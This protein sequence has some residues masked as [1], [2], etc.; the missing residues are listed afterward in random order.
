MSNV[1]KWDRWYEGLQ[2]SPSSFRFADTITYELGAKFLQDCAVVEDWGVGAGGFKRYRPDAIGIDGSKTPFADKIAD[3]VSYRSHVDGIFMRHV[4]EHNYGWRRIL[5][6]AL[7]SAKKICVVLFVPFSKGETI[8]LA[9]NAPHG[10]DVPDLSLSK[11][12]FNAVL[13]SA[14]VKEARSFIYKN[15]S[16]YGQETI[17]YIALDAVMGP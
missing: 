16:G 4:L 13:N 12:E 15:D 11:T 7:H 6:N 9:D 17:F 5:E 1:G 14:G 2:D 8:K 3:L 10:V